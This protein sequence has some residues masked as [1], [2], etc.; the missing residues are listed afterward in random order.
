MVDEDPNSM[1]EDHL[2]P[3]LGG[4]H[5]MIKILLMTA[6]LTALIASPAFSRHSVASKNPARVYAQALSGQVGTPSISKRCPP[7]AGSPLIFF[8][9]QTLRVLGRLPG[10]W[11]GVA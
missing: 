5:D 8:R 1:G 11:R 3:K 6:A 7:S 2:A 10:A 9:N 4:G